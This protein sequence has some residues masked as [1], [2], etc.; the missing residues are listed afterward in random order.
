MARERVSKEICQS[1]IEE[2]ISNELEEIAE[3]VFQEAKAERDAKLQL[4]AGY[5]KRS[6]TAKYF[7]RCALTCSIQICRELIALNVDPTRHP[8][9]PLLGLVLP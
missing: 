9:P 8:L 2:K 5:V 1:L 3:E 6:R 4:L 7:K